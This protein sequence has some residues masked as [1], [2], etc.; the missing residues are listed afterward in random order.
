[1]QLYDYILRT[2]TLTQAKN[3]VAE[4]LLFIYLFILF[5]TYSLFKTLN[6]RLS[7]LHYITLH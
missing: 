6:I 2:F 1:M 3:F 5:F 4:E 7:I